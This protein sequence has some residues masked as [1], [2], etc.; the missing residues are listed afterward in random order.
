MEKQNP[1]RKFF[2]WNTLWVVLISCAI[3][4]CV[5]IGFHG[6]PLMGLPR[7]EAV[8]SVT[9]LYNGTDER[10]VTDKEKVELLVKSANLLNYQLRGE[11][12]GSPVI[13]ITYH[14]E[15][16]KSVSIEANETTM[17]WKGKAHAL[18]ETEVFVNVIQGLFFDQ[19]D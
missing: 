18:K 14:L 19:G 12:K 8:K 10:T 3:N 4:A 1:A 6:I 9:L 7:K 17:W 2:S 11:T 16:G 5:W 15:N 13:T